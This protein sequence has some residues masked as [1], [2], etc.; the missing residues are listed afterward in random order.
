MDNW[1]LSLQQHLNSDNFQVV[2][3]DT[4]VRSQMDVGP[5]KVRNR[6]TKG[7]DLYTAS[8][9]LDIDDYDTLSNFFKTTLGNGSL[10]FLFHNPLTD[11]DETFR[12][13]APPAIKPLGGRIFRIDMTWE[14]MP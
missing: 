3:G 11:A 13:K 10:P 2:L 8:V 4:L 9:N 12:F 1:P 6:Y 14:R 7:V 5:D